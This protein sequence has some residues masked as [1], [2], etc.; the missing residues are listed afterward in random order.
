MVPPFC[1]PGSASRTALART[2]AYRPFCAASCGICGCMRSTGAIDGMATSFSCWEDLR[3]QQ[4]TCWRLDCSRPDRKAAHRP[5][6]EVSSP[7]P[8]YS[9][10]PCT[11]WQSPAWNSPPL[12]CRTAPL[13][14]QNGPNHPSDIASND[15]MRCN[16][17]QINIYNMYRRSGARARTSTGK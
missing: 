2:K 12:T 16:I 11:P 8:S 10:S 4:R 9:E 17:Y 3:M 1:F 14:S 5:L 7:V 15:A 13:K 6:K